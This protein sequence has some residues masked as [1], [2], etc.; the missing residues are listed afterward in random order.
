MSLVL[1]EYDFELLLPCQT[2]LFMQWNLSH[3]EI[4]IENIRKKCVLNIYLVRNVIT[5][6]ARRCEIRGVCSSLLTNVT[7]SVDESWTQ[8]HGFWIRGLPCHQTWGMDIW[9]WVTDIHAASNN[10]HP[11]SKW[12]QWPAIWARLPV[13][14]VNFCLTR[15]QL[16][17]F[18]A[19]A[20]VFLQQRISKLSL[21]PV[22]CH[23]VSSKGTAVM[24]KW[25]FQLQGSTDAFCKHPHSTQRQMS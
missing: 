3:V 7:Q 22:W 14:L 10:H 11:N 23:W 13:D 15:G 9:Y 25:L 21:Q 1:A 16:T 19:L 24:D 8:T 20:D 2:K 6:N 12:T 17:D 4:C 18:S 5:P